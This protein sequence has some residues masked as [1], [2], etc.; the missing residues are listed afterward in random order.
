MFIFQLIQVS[1]AQIGNSCNQDYSPCTCTPNGLDIYID[2]I[3]TPIEEVIR[4][5][6][7]T[8][9]NKHI[10]TFS[11]LDFVPNELGIPDNILGDRQVIILVLQCKTFTPLLIAND[12]FKET[13]YYTS[14]ME[15]TG[16]NLFD[17]N[18]GFLEGF[19]KLLSLKLDSISNMALIFPNFPI[20][21]SAM[22]SLTMTNCHGWENLT[23]VPAT[24]FQGKLK[25]LYITNSKDMVDEAMDIVMKWVLKSFEFTMENLF[26]YNNNLNQVPHEIQ[27]L[28]RLGFLDLK[29]NFLPLILT[30]SFIFIKK[31]PVTFVDLSKCGVNEIQP[32]AFQGKR[33]KKILW[34]FKLTIK[35]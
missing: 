5:F 32:H 19:N 29:N 6:K 22:T 23:N 2:C 13:K 18:M 3:D 9:A 25:Q 28:S 14:E 20:R 16:C 31:N 27:S 34:Q 1:E 10:V 12:S 30:D 4:V 21:L 33:A 35:M 15:I 26:L 17:S 11:L 24:M 7:E 8:Q